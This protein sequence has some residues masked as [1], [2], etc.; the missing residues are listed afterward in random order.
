MQPQPRKRRAHLWLW[1][2]L[3]LGGGGLA[4]RFWVGDLYRVVSSSMEPTLL[5]GDRVWV[6]YGTSDLKRND[7]AVF[8][9][10]AG[11]AVVKRLAGLPNEE[12]LIDDAGDLWVDRHRPERSGLWVPIFDDSLLKLDEYF[13]H[14]G[15]GVDPWS[16]GDGFW[17]VDATAVQLGHSQGM[18]RY[19]D[20][21]HSGRLTPDGR[22]LRGQEEVGDVRLSLDVWI[23][24]PTGVLRLELTEW[25]DSFQIWV[26]LDHAGHGLVCLY[27]P[28]SFRGKLET[29]ACA[30]PLKQWIPMVLQNCDNR[31][32]FRVQGQLVLSHEYLANTPSPLG[33]IGERVLFG[34]TGAMLRFRNVRI[35]RDVTYTQLG[36]HG[37]RKRLQLSNDEYFF[38][39]DNS[40]VS[41]DSRSLGPV[42]RSR[43]VGRARRILWP[44]ARRRP[45]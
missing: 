5:P 31:I 18:M 43:V 3:A 35:D 36:Q 32:E 16:K 15:Q 28:P 29:A 34:G 20:G 4:V 42:D 45:L 30:L 7:L 10:T 19:R 24:Q 2:L 26:G 8:R 11:E 6:S 9:N 14:G 40:P 22:I 37:V 25:A 41:E 33:S 17:Q 12:V 23:E 13:L 27:R 38:L 21:V 39:G 44:W 1:C